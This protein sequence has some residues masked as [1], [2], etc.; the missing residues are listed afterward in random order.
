MCGAPADVAP[1]V[2]VAAKQTVSENRIEIEVRREALNMKV[3]WP[4]AG[5]AQC[6][7]C[8]R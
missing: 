2:P 3:T 4:M 6:P 8:A 7:A 5:A 1:F